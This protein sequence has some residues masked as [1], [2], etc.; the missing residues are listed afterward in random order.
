MGW[1]GFVLDVEVREFFWAGIWV[2]SWFFCGYIKIWGKNIL[3][4][5]YMCKYFD[6]EVVSV[7]L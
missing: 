4:R 6:V 5:G 7:S 3:D 2:E 1:E